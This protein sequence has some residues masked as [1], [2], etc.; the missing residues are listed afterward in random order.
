MN[1]EY[2]ENV[3]HSLWLSCRTTNLQACLATW[4]RH[5]SNT[6]A[7]EGCRFLPRTESIAL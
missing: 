3:C 6:L 7:N 4:R 2:L 5:C 1:S